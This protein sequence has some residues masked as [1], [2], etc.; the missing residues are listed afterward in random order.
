MR[1]RRKEIADL[2]K[3]GNSVISAVNN[4]NNNSLVLVVVAKEDDFVTINIGLLKCNTH[5][6]CK[7][8]GSRLPI[9]VEKSVDA[10][11]ILDTT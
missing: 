9:K 2:A 11:T 7:M 1:K 5:G 3:K 4:D 8:R 10:K 6:L